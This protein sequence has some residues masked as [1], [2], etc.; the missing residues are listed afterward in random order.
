MP[1]HVLWL[2]VSPQSQTANRETSAEIA[3][4]QLLRLHAVPVRTPSSHEP[5]PKDSQ[6]QTPLM[7]GA[8]GSTLRAPVTLRVVRLRL[9]GDPRAPPTGAAEPP[10][11]SGSLLPVRSPRCKLLDTRRVMIFCPRQ[12]LQRRHATHLFFLQNP[13]LLYQGCHVR[14]RGCTTIVLCCKLASS[15]ERSLG[16][17]NFLSNLRELGCI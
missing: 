12:P 10:V 6:G 4:R 8:L 7:Q 14:S 1:S 16:Q 13:Q 2:E 9:A 11:P 17:T 5:L 3:G 15:F